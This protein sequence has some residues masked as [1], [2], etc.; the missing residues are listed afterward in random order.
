MPEKQRTQK[1][2][3]WQISFNAK[4]TGWCLSGHAT[5]KV[6]QNFAMRNE[7]EDKSRLSLPVRV[8]FFHVVPYTT[9]LFSGKPF[10]LLPPP[11]GLSETK[12]RTYL[13]L[14]LGLSVWCLDF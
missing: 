13:D 2:Q 14:T 5:E 7:N 10:S 4:S 8:L 9:R 12:L 11:I 6:L 3:K 1:G